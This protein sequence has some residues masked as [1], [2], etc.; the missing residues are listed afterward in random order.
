MA[1]RL[2]NGGHSNEG[3]V[4]VCYSG[5]WGTVCEDEWDAL[6][7]GVVCRQ[8]GYAA[9]ERVYTSG[10]Y[11]S[12]EGVIWMD[13]LQCTGKQ[14]QFC[15]QIVDSCNQMCMTTT[16]EIPTDPCFHF[17]CTGEETRLEECQ[18]KGWGVTDCTH[19]MD[20]GVVCTGQNG[21][22]VG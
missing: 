20:A 3:R 9:A 17:D 1:I 5:R 6:D 19:D 11:G 15:L 22:L 10:F 13:N 16:R 2:S 12:G 7:G 21:H 4:E 14:C 18:F 8:L